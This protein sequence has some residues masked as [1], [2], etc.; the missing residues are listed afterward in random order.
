M[1]NCQQKDLI[2]FGLTF[3]E[4]MREVDLLVNKN[5][6][7]SDPCIINCTNH[8]P[9]DRQVVEILCRF[10]VVRSAIGHWLV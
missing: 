10:V 2:D 4:M 8:G 3:L 1:L 5:F 7:F 6:S 9:R